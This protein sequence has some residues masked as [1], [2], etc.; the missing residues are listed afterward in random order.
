M[1][2]DRGGCQRRYEATL[3]CNRIAQRVRVVE[4]CE[5]EK[6]TVV[7]GHGPNRRD[8][9]RGLAGELASAFGDDLRRDREFG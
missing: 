6:E 8:V 4:G 1:C 5:S 2:D 3:R 7:L 9:R